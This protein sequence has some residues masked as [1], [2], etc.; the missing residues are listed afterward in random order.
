MA[1]SVPI[2]YNLF[3]EFVDTFIGDGF[4]AIDP[5]HPLMVELEEMMEAG[6]QFFYVADILQMKIL[7]TSKGSF[8][9]IGIEPDELNF[10]HFMEVT[11]PEEVPRLGLGR[12]LVIRLGQELY[13]VEEGIRILSTSFHMRNP[14]GEYSLVM[15][16]CYFVVV[17]QPKKRVY[18][19]KLHTTVD[20]NQ[21]K[22]DKFHYYLGEDL[23]MF[24][25]PDKELLEMGILLSDR[26]FEIIKLIAEG[27]SSEQIAEK[28]FLSINTVHTHR[29]NILRK[30]GKES[31]SE[32][33]LSLKE[34]GLM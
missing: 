14:S 31:T 7:F 9:M 19:M 23:S 8:R 5:D 28:L 4:N 26:E 20:W 18:F 33:I 22:R 27:L 21:K 30:S 3:L 1:F 12:S 34:R 15:V 25:Y 11:H 10:N 32:I 17:S 24:R 16:Q 13:Q 6:K 2:D 29:A